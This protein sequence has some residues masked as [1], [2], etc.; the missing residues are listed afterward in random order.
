MIYMEPQ[1][2]GWRPL[3]KS[4][5]NRLPSTL[6]EVHKSVLNDM[7]ERFVDAGLQLVH[8]SGVK[9]KHIFQFFSCHEILCLATNLIVL[10]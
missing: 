8:K 5:M 4:W 10:Y 9:V 2:L 6:T 3:V 1:T 7:F